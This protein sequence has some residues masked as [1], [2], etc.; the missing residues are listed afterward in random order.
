M[1]PSDVFRIFRESTARADC[2]GNTSS[3]VIVSEAGEGERGRWLE[4][5]QGHEKRRRAHRQWLPEE[6]ARPLQVVDGPHH[7]I[8]LVNELIS[9]G[10]IQYMWPRTVGPSSEAVTF[11]E[12][13]VC[14][15]TK[16]LHA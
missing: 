8:S 4:N 5:F 16:R 2:R 7:E 12:V 1:Y 11:G 9:A 15:G 6:G 3:C 13:M 10:I 14:V